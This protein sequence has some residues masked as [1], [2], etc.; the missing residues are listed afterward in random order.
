M[1]HVTH[2]DNPGPGLDDYSTIAAS[3]V[4]IARKI[5]AR[6]FTHPVIVPLSAVESSVLR[7]INR[8]PGI[9]PSEI[10][11]NLRI[12]ASNTSAALRELE[13]QALVVRSV[14]A[15]DRRGVHVTVTAKGASVI[16]QVRLEWGQL[17]A[18]LIPVDLDVAAAARALAA[19]DDALNRAD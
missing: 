5:Q 15:A 16:A 7:H 6:G 2:T 13:A 9:T 17:L 12:Q 3:A 19:I 10:G 14:D 18:G 11:A 8:F 1:D 4:S